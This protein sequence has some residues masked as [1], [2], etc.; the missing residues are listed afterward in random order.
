MVYKGS[1]H[2]TKHL[3]RDNVDEVYEKHNQR[4]CE[5]AARWM[6]AVDVRR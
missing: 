2:G 3:L 4:A 6:E 1:K 5:L